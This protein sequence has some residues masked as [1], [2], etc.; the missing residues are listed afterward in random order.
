MNKYINKYVTIK[1]NIKYI[2]FLIEVNYETT[3]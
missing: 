1:V 3:A 2:I